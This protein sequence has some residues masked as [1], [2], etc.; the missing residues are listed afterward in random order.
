MAKQD[1]PAVGF[2]EQL[3]RVELEALKE[4]FQPP[5][6]VLEVGAGSG[7]QAAILKSWGCQVVAIDVPHR[8]RSP[9]RPTW[10]PILDYDG[11]H[12]PFRDSCFDIVFS[13]NVLEHVE[14]LHHLLIE[15]RRVL[16]DTGFVIHV[17]PTSGV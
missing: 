8:P 15:T 14:D 4:Y 9:S 2:L 16:K 10:Y 6:L 12:M 5:K 7:W 13:P 17:V 1:T 3:R 11:L